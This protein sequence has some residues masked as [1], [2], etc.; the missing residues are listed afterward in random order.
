[1]IEINNLTTSTV[2]E[3]FLKGVAR[4]VLKGENQTSRSAPCNSF[5]IKQTSRSAPC[6]CQA[7]K[8]KEIDLSIVFV[9][10]G[11]IRKLNKK[12]REKNKV[13]D[14]LSFGEELNEVVICLREV[15]KNAKKYNLT[16]KKELARVLIHGI[17]HLLGYEHEKS[18]KEAEKMEKKEEYYL[19]NLDL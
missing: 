5:G 15:K 19:S 2:D 4:M 10:Q 1:M 9:G 14:V 8:K 11:R 7:I 16:L 12:Y 17:L 6:N 13:T 18:K 3:E